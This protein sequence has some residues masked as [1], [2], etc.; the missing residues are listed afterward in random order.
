MQGWI[1]L[2][3]NIQ[4]NWIWTEKPFDKRSAWIDILLM[5]NHKD[6][7]FLLG[8]ELVEVE[9]G[10]FITSE[11][12]LMERWGW[13]KSKVR[14][15]LKVLENDSMIVKK[16][17][18]KKTT[19][20][21]VKYRDYQ[22]SETT[23]EPQKDHEKTTKEPQKDTNKNDKNDNNEKNDNNLYK[24]IVDRWNNIKGLSN[25]KKL[26]DTRKKHLNARIIEHGID[27]IYLVLDLVSK[28]NFLQGNNNRNWKCDFD[29]VI[30]PNNFLKVLEGKYNKEINIE[31]NLET[32][33]TQ[34]RGFDF[35]GV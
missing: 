3:R 23:E 34:Y 8:N 20:T 1:K 2:H 31:S 7:K 35:D 11:I 10:S 33:Q 6:N 24:D 30:N 15:F 25:I 13:S 9:A 17:D 29:W 14:N 16:T 27:N 26:S 32:K 21:V 12:K 4:A 18:H 28:S 22:V 19:L 5:A